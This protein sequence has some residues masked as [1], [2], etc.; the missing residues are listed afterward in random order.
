MAELAGRHV[1]E[2]Q[3]VIELCMHK[4][5]SGGKTFASSQAFLMLLLLLAHREKERKR[6][7]LL[8]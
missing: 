1:C 5:A 4:N 2:F 8:L 3:K 6:F 7:L